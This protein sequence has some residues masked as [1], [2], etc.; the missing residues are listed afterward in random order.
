MVSESDRIGDDRM[1]SIFLNN[2]LRKEYICRRMGIVSSAD[3]NR[4]ISKALEKRRHRASME[5]FKS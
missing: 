4:V 2:N 5:D 3:I 1:K